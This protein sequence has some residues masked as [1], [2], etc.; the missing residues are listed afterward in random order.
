MAIKN[1]YFECF[2][3]ATLVAVVVTP[4]F[5]KL[6]I[7]TN[8][9]DHP[10]SSVKTH[11][12][13]TPYLGGLAVALAMAVGL[14]YTRA[15]TNYPTGTLRSLRGLMFGGILILILGLI[16]DIKL[17]GLSYRFKFLIQIAA[18]ICLLAFDIRIHFINPAWL[19]NILTVVWVVGIINAVN[20]IDIMDGLAS[21]IAVVASLGFF[22]ISL[23]F[24][25]VHVNITAVALAGALLG[26]MPY[27][28]SNKRKIF[29]GDTG[30]LFVGFTLAALS[31]GT[32]YTHVNNAGVFAP[33][34]ILGVPIYDT[35]LVTV[36][37]LQKG[38]SPFL[39]SH[40]HFALRLER[41][42]FYREEILVI[43]YA[44][45]LLLTF[46]AYEV[47]IV[48]FEYAMLIY[49]ISGGIAGV[50]GSWLAKI[51]IS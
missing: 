14:L 38:V 1:L 26:F 23:P 43:S 2:F 40:D 6:A 30:S 50:L 16:D 42:G 10:V 3:L 22:F 33:L 34:L 37:R 51:R 27:N 28:F 39:G 12:Q 24:E 31:L 46:V 9:L 35:I 25:Q 20:I 11:K 8:V 17:K 18:A 32:S 36:L 41:Y 19:G 5:R 29:L 21:G 4:L 47:T 48:K 7:A 15:Y 13:P 45:S 49:L 44:A